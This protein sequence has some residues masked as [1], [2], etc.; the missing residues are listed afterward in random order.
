M[1]SARVLVLIGLAFH[2]VYIFSIFDIYFRSPLTHGMPPHTPPSGP[3]A[4]RLV[5][6]VGR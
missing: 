3:L 4:Q 6:F 2:C 5:F 1:V